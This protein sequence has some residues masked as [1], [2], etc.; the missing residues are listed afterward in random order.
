MWYIVGYQVGKVYVTIRLEG[1]EVKT[2]EQLVKAGATKS[3]SDF[4]RGAT[5]MLL[6]QYTGEPDINNIEK[7][8]RTLESNFNQLKAKM[9]TVINGL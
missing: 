5:K 8:L 6:S 2:I 4:I 1:S 9:E 7:R 3:K